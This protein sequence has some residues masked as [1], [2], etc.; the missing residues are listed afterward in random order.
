MVFERR[1]RLTKL[2]EMNK[3]ENVIENIIYVTKTVIVKMY[4]DT[5]RRRDYLISPRVAGH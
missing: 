3:I 5:T 4:Y 1:Q 2:G